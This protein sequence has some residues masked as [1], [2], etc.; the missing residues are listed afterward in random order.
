M[1]VIMTALAVEQQAVLDHLINVEEHSHAM[2]TVFDVGRLASRP[3]RRVA[4][5]VTGP[6]TTTAAA[7]TER[8][9]TEFSP[10]AMMFVG[11]AGGLRKWLK[12]GDVVVATKVYSHHG[13]RSEDNADLARPRAWEVSH[14]LEQRARR[15]DRGDSWYSHLS[16]DAGRLRP[17]VHF[18]PIVAG[19][20][21][22]NSRTSP[23]ALTLSTVY[24]DAVAIEMESS[25]FAHAA[26]LGGNV[27]VVTIRAVS[28][29]ANGDKAKQDGEGTQIV[30]ARTAAAFAVALAAAI[31]DQ[32]DDGQDDVEDPRH[33]QASTMIRNSN[34]ARG[35]ARVGQQI[36]INL[37]DLGARWK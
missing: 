18:D 22:L 12:I 20:V 16:D 8:A 4:L 10:S 23:L 27:P 24:N 14:A 33:A 36:G 25:G 28:D 15:L 30:A 26:H 9:R 7:L 6:G 2:G 1:I 37:G 29:H 13:A 34:N 17:R 35:K 5:G 21:L 3:S 31:V 11:V 32:D 19:D